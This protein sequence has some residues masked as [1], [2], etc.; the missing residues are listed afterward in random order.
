MEPG[1]SRRFFW[2]LAVLL[3]LA[4]PVNA[5]AK[6]R[7]IQS[8]SPGAVAAGQDVQLR[9]SIQEFLLPAVATLYY[10][11]IGSADY[12][13]LPM[14]WDSEIVF[15]A[16]LPGQRLLPPGIEYFFAVEDGRGRVFTSPELDPRENPFSIPVSLGVAAL[17]Q[18][19]FPPH[20]RFQG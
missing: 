9:I 17:H 15:S 8:T 10:R 11:P 2:V 16:I 6:E 5:L 3:A 19:A 4:A 20:G 18:L 14:T 1:R 12:R 7:I 13:S